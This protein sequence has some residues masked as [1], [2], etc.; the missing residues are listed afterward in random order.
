MT[1]LM[2]T[3]YQHLLQQQCQAVHPLLLLL[4]VPVQQQQAEACTPATAAAAVAA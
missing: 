3:Q 2:R 4:K 1:V